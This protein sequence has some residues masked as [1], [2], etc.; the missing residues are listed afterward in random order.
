MNISDKGVATLKNASGVTPKNKYNIVQLKQYIQGA[1]DKSKSTS[2]EE[3]ANFWN[4][5]PGEIVEMILLYALQQWE[6][7]VPGHKCETYASIKSTCRKWARIIDGKGPALLPK[8]YIDTWKPLGK[9]YNGKIILSTRKVTSTFG[10][11]SG[12]VSQLLNSI[13]DKKWRSSWFLTP[14]KQSWYTIDR[15]F[16]KTKVRQLNQ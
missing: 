14:G 11:S 8:I 13:G 6:N 15:I 4:H 3:P 16:W 10:K 5:A 2:N 1:D 9:P 7:S 12:L